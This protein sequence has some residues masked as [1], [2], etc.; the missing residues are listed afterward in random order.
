[1]FDYKSFFAEHDAEL[2]RM[3]LIASVRENPDQVLDIVL[4]HQLLLFCVDL[5]VLNC[6]PALKFKE[7]TV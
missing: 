5:S 1:M 2:V 3:E 4:K 6:L 7:N